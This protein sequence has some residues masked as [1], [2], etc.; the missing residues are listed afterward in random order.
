MAAGPRVTVVVPTRDRPDALTRCLAALER[1]TRRRLR[2]RRR[3]RSVAPTA[4]TCAAAVAGATRATGRRGRGGVR[5]RRATS[6]WLAVGEIVCFTD[7]DCRP[8]AGWLAALEQRLRRRRRRRGRTDRS[9][10][11]G[12][13]VA[14]RRS[15]SPTTSSTSRVTRAARSGSRRPATSPCRRAVHRSAPFDET[16]PTAAGE[17]RAWCDRLRASWAPDR[18]R[19]RGLGAPRAGA[20]RCAACGAST[21]ATARGAYRY[22]SAPAV[23]TRR[24]SAGF[25]ARLFRRG[26]RR[27]RG[28]RASSSLMTQVA[29]AV[30]LAARPTG[31]APGS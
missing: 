19:R 7:D 18:V 31:R 17:D 9:P 12:V 16:F 2:G 11:G 26:V 29:T 24:Q 30:G 27:G 3:R 20:R 13:V 15:S 25:Y 28:D 14:A 10:T 22:L 6:G 21:R 5:P 23:G 4:T 8:G 1:Q